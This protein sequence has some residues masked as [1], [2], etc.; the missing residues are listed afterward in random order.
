MPNFRRERANS[1]IQ[2]ELTLLLRRSVRDPRVQHITVTDVDLTVDRRIARVYVACYEGEEALQEGL[3][4][5]E[6]AKAFLRRE[7]GQ[8]LHWRFTP[9]LEFR[10]DRSWQKGAKIDRLLRELNSGEAESTGAED[11]A[12]DE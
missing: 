3:A 12:Q 6:S 5:L 1:F 2:E 9:E 7:I 4:G 11:E 8:L 10:V